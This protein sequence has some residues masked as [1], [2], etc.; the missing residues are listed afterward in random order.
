MTDKLQK[1]KPDEVQILT[2][3]VKGFAKEDILKKYNTTEAKYK[4]VQRLYA[5][6]GTSDIDNVIDKLTKKASL[7]KAADLLDVQVMDDITGLTRLD[8]N[9]QNTANEI[10][11][12]LHNLLGD[13]NNAVELLTIVQAFTLLRKSMFDKGIVVNSQTNINHA[14]IIG[15]RA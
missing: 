12:K 9:M 14:K 4:K 15:N 8:H 11:T 7:T 2:G 3:L 5:E 10:N 1:L 13:T 6:A